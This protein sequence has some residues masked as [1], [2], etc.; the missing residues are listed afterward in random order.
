MANVAMEE[1]NTN[2]EAQE[3]FEKSNWSSKVCYINVAYRG[4]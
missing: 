4:R 2:A 1:N 3:Q